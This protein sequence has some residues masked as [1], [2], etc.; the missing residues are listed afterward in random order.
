MNTRKTVSVTI[1]IAMAL[2]VALSVCGGCAARNEG[3]SQEPGAGRETGTNPGTT[4]PGVTDLS[5]ANPGVA[6][7]NVTGSSATGPGAADPANLGSAPGSSGQAYPNRNTG[8]WPV[9]EYDHPNLVDYG[10]SVAITFSEQMF[11]GVELSDEFIEINGYID[12][13][14]NDD[15]SVTIVMSKSR[16]QMFLS[17]FREDVNFNIEYFLSEIDYL[18]DIAFS[19]DMRY[20]DIYVDGS[21]EIEI[22]YEM[23]YFFSLPLEQYQITLGQE[24][25]TT[26]S[27]IDADTKATI[28]TLV[29]PDVEQ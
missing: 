28:M 3:G 7:P 29:F 21:T 19:D 13:M 11:E 25:R 6:D 27:V 2:I 4:A 12:G 16:Q 14:R 22:L 26:I 8:D 15:G 9:L 17:S 5:A 10:D 20:M 1:A 23:P 18:K 24:V